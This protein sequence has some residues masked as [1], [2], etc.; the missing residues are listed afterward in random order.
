LERGLSALWRWEMIIEL[1]ETV[2]DE[3]AERVRRKIEEATPEF[4]QQPDPEALASQRILARIYA[5]ENISIQEAA[6]LLNCSDGH[7]RNLVKKARA[8]K[9][10]H[11][12]PFLDLDGV[13]T[14][15]REEL[16]AW[17][18]RPKDKQKPKS[19]QKLEVVSR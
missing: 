7:L 3:I 8:G 14:F 11:P 18:R 4:N 1:P 17:S 16:L 12:I 15:N 9:T 6:F 5:K 19:K 2:I 13:V 10:Q